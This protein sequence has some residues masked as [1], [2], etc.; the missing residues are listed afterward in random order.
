MRRVYDPYEDR[1][2]MEDVREIELRDPVM[3]ADDWENS[4]GW[5]LSTDTRTTQTMIP[6]PINLGR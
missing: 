6:R 1:F 3:S 4:T 5:R 2:S